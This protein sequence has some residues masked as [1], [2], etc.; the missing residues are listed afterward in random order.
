LGR[1][2]TSSINVPVNYWFSIFHTVFKILS[3]LDSSFSANV[4][5]EA[6]YL[7]ELMALQLSNDIVDWDAALETSP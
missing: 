6:E 7:R 5:Q 1:P 3:V 4:R 2:F